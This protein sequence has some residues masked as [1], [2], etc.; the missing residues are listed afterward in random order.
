VRRKLKFSPRAFGAVREAGAL[1]RSHARSGHRA[2]LPH[3][4]A[5]GGRRDFFGDYF[6]A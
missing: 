5:A 3:R 1:K 6:T 4:A 2:A